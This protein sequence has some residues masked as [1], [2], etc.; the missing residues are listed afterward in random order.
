MP[1][2]PT[3]WFTKN[4]SPTLHRVREAASRYPTLASHTS[5]DAGYLGAAQEAFLEPVGIGPEAYPDY[6]L[7]VVRRR[8]VGAVVG[9]RHVAHLAAHRADFEALGCRLIVASREP[10]TFE[11]CE[12]KARFYA[13]FSGRLPMPETRVAHTWEELLAHAGELEARHGSA[14]FKPARGIYGHGFR[15]LTRED[16]LERFFSGD[17]LQ[18]SHAAAELLLKDQAL[19]P[20]L[21][22]ETLPG[23]EYSVDAVAHS[24]ALLAVVVRRKVGGLGN[25]QQSVSLPELESY[26][27]LLARELQ[28]DGL[29]NV[30]FKED[31]DGQP[32][33]LE[34]NARASG[35][36]R[37]ARR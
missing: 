37:S 17:R 3:V 14:C 21:V 33:L 27:A 36:W 30:Q 1:A 19:P 25:V 28:M 7:E 24:G 13:D 4:I 34:V 16:S 18:L 5:A 11:R 23:Q 26:A 15:I 32:R 31:R 20:L 10:G 6:A 9:G 8:G 35:G 22:M 12:D 2:S 29:F